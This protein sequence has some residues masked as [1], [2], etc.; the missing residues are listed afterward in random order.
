LSHFRDRLRYFLTGLYVLFTYLLNKYV[1]KKLT[2]RQQC[3]KPNDFRLANETLVKKKYNCV[4]QT[5]SHT[6]ACNVI[7]FILYLLSYCVCCYFTCAYIHFKFL[8]QIRN[9]SAF[10]TTF[11]KVR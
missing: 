5:A 1:W 6:F 11:N 7:F 10:W 8:M 2:K 9:F 4:R 3:K